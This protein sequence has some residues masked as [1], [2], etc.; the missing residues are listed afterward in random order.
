MAKTNKP[1][2]LDS[3]DL[4]SHK[5]NLTLRLTNPQGNQVYY[6]SERLKTFTLDLQELSDATG[7][8]NFSGCKVTVKDDNNTITEY[9][10]NAE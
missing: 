10:I 3:L 6:G 9:V 7:I 4:N 8:T 5:G 1:I 2:T